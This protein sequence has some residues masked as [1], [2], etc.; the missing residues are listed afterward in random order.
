MV[1]IALDCRTSFDVKY[2]LINKKMAIWSAYR[3]LN[4]KKKNR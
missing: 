3:L 4:P 1:A 2:T